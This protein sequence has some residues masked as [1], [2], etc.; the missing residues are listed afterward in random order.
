MEAAPPIESSET[1]RARRARAL[2]EAIDDAVFVHDFDGHI[3]D[4]NPAACRR[5]G[6]SREELL[7]LTTR[8]IDAP[9]FAKAFDER[10]ARQQKD[11]KLICEGRHVTKLGK[12]FPV[13][14]STSLVEIDGVPAILAVVRDITARKKAERRQDVLYGVTTILA[15]SDSF[16]AAAP[17]ILKAMGEGMDWDFGAIWLTDSHTDQLHCVDCWHPST[18]SYPRFKAVT[19]RSRFARGVGMPGRAWLTGDAVWIADVVSDPNFPRAPVARE[20]GFHSG[21]AFPIQYGP[22]TLGIIEFFQKSFVKP[23]DDLLAMLASL[24]SQIG[25]FIEGTRFENALRESEAF[26]QSLVEGLPQNIIRKDREGRF[27]FVNKRGLKGLGKELKEVVG[28]TDFDLFPKE[29]AQKYRKDDLHVLATGA[30]LEAVEEHISPSGEKLYMQIVKTPIYDSHNELIGTQVIYWDVTERKRWEEALSHSERRYRQLMEAAQDA[31]IVA[32]Q[33][34][35]ITLFNPAAERAFGYAALEIVGRPVSVLIPEE[36]RASHEFGMKRFLETRM[37]RLIGKPIEMKGLRKDG[38]SFP[39]ELSLSSFELGGELQFL[40]IIR[41]TTERNRMRSAL[42]QSEKLASIGLLSAGVAHE[43]NNPLTYVANNLVVLER[44][45]KGLMA[46]I[47]LYENM[48][49]RLTEMDPEVG[50]RVKNLAEEIDLCYVRDNLSRVLTRT[51]EGVQR[52][53]RIVQ[54]LRGLARTDRPKLEDTSVADIVE[55]SLELIRGRLQRHGIALE[56][57]LQA[58]RIRCVPTQIGQVFLNLLVNSLQAIEAK[59]TAEKHVIRI[60]SQYVNDEILFE[61]SDTGAGIDLQDIPRLFD[62]FFTTK[63]VGEGTGLGLSITHGIISGHGGRI[64][65]SSKPGEGTT[66]KIYLP[67]QAQLKD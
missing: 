36:F 66:F 62:P 49:E 3:L 19:R 2:F 34:S 58:G 48:R 32:D 15:E 37:P 51:R 21:F 61:I 33:T 60:S 65:V 64:E 1:M 11:G 52:V 22:E 16:A 12:V 63:P 29:L 18:A 10:L 20:E 17:R 35:R 47:E 7:H 40:G 54:N 31:I 9:E 25:Q 14:I 4:A 43:I 30:N 56:T 26:Y 23:D 8:D 67:Q 57:H 55:M 42:V 53:A 50:L 46:L 28:K 44:D 59:G 5:L 38:H 45:L 27:M 13:E 6:Y 41:D 39:L 24:G